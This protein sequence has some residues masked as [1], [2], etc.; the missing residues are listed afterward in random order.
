MYNI[1]YVLSENRKQRKI[2]EKKPIASED[3]ILLSEKWL[4]AFQ[5]PN[6]KKNTKSSISV[7]QFYAPGFYEA[8]DIV[9]TYAEKLRVTILWFKEKRNCGYNYINNNYPQLESFC[10]YCN[11]KFNHI[12]PIPCI[13]ED[14]LAGFCSSECML[15]HYKMRHKV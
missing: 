12:E 15:D 4:V 8:Y 2:Q 5:N 9:A 7:R 6:S 13:K 11:N 14:C 10:T 1:N 3:E